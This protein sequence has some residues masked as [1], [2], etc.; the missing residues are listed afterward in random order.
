LTGALIRIPITG[1]ETLSYVVFWDEVE[2]EAVPFEG[3]KTRK[4]YNLWTTDEWQIW[5]EDGKGS[6]EQIDGGK[7]PCKAVPI[8]PCF[9]SKKGHMTGESAIADVVSLCKRAYRLGSCLDKSLY[10]TGF[11]LQLFL[12]FTKEEIDNFK[13]ASSSGLVSQDTQAD[14]KFI[15]PNGDFIQRAEG[16]HQRR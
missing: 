7:H 12:G 8:V 1:A 4:E 11:P 15:E 6:A 16:F 10:D 14:S 3:H 5:I 9:F 2:T 13:R